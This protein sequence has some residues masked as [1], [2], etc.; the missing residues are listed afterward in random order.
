MKV[1]PI[2]ERQLEYARSVAGKLTDLGFRVELDERG[3]KIGYKI[4]EAQLEKIPYMLVVGDKEVEAS[5]VGVRGRKTGDL[6]QMSLDA[7]AARLSQEVR[8]KTMD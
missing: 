8:D 2:S 4:R 7:L 3:E 1:L 6:G 5:A